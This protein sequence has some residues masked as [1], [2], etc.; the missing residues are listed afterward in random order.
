MPGLTDSTAERGRPG[1]PGPE[2]K[3][4]KGV[5]DDAKD[6]IRSGQTTRLYARP[7]ILVTGTEAKCRS[8]WTA[9]TCAG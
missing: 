9:M 6:A 3:Q 5:H 2:E 1:E 4:R 8:S 7:A